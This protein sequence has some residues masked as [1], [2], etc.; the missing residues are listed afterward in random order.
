MCARLSGMPAGI[1]NVLSENMRR[2][3][4]ERGL[5]MSDLARGAGISVSYWSYLESEPERNPSIGVIAQI[6]VSLG[7]RTTDLLQPRRRRN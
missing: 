5:S 2:L 1:G 6:A 4:E 7:V 3:R